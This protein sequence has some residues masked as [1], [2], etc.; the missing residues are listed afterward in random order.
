MAQ[1]ESLVEASAG[2]RHRVILA[3][4]EIAA[5]LIAFFPVRLGPEAELTQGAKKASAH[6]SDWIL[7]FG[8]DH[9]IDHPRNQAVTFHAP[10][11][12]RQD[13]G[14]DVGH[15][16]LQFAGT[17]RRGR[18]DVQDRNALLVREQFY[19]VTRLERPEPRVFQ[20]GHTYPQE[21]TIPCGA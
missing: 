2:H 1:R 15:G 14:R 12:L 13:L 20:F 11:G 9:G 21:S 3:T 17:Q 18:E 10:E 6:A 19:G 5:G 7:H 8:R 16:S 4:V